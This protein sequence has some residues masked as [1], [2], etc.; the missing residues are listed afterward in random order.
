M[1]EDTA[2]SRIKG[3][4][5]PDYYLE[6]YGR[7]S[8]KAYQTF[9]KAAE[10]KST[11]VDSSGIVEPKIAFDLADRVAKM[12]DIDIADPLRELLKVKGKEACSPRTIKKHC[13]GKLLA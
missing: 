3:V 8:E 4:P 6:Y 11:H 1:S 5:M 13:L 9:E 12:H 10:A 7:L 2:I